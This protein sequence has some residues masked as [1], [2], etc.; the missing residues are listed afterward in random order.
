MCCVWLS[1]ANIRS[2]LL[3]CPPGS[4]INLYIHLHFHSFFKFPPV[5]AFSSTISPLI[6][7]FTNPSIESIIYTFIIYILY[8]HVYISICW[9]VYLIFIHTWIL[10]SHIH[11]LTHSFVHWT[12]TTI[13]GCS[14][15]KNLTWVLILEDVVSALEKFTNQSRGQRSKCRI[16]NSA[17][18]G[19]SRREQE[20]EKR[21]K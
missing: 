12:T 13:I 20:V 18:P 8:I 6:H 21:N 9:V 17:W 16:S 14:L 15:C 1:T 5:S 19:W 11:S 2:S 10:S 4:I 3:P 7:H